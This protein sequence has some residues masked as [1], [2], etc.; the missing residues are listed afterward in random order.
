MVVIFNSSPIIFLSKLGL[1]NEALSLF[2][3]SYIPNSAIEEILLKKDESSRICSELLKCKKL[4]KVKAKNRRLFTALNRKL[5]KGESESIV[6]AIENEKVNFVILDDHVARKEAL[7]LGLKV[8]GTLGII[9]RLYKL[10]RLSNFP[11]EELYKKLLNINFR[12]KEEIF[13]EIFKEWLC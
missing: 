11:V 7:R 9:R 6:F 8:K 12:V 3:I 13:K 4:I 10:G 1:I 2:K 5:G